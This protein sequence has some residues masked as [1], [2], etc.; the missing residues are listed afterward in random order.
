MGLWKGIRMDWELVGRQIYFCVGN[1][2]RVRFWKDRW[3]GDSLLCESFPSLFALSAE[4]EAWVAD[5]W[6]P[7]AEG[8][9]GSWNPCFSRALN[10]WEVEK[11]KYF[12]T[13]F[14]GRECLEM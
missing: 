11:G 5:V 9:W 13:V 12:W 6:D 10:D 4:K 7:L 2:R 3:C 8:G 14:T 1:G